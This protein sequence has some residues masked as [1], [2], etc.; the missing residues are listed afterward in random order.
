MDTYMF[1]ARSVKGDEFVWWNMETIQTEAGMQ[2]TS[3][4]FQ[5]DLSVHEV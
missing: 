1:W 5:E 2:F 3:K 4:D